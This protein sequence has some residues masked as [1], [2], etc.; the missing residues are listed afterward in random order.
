[1]NN[2]NVKLMVED[3]LKYERLENELAA[4]GEY[5]RAQNTNVQKWKVKKAAEEYGVENEF[6]QQ[7]KEARKKL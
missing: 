2:T 4:R 5:D 6:L 7:L 1:M 3:F